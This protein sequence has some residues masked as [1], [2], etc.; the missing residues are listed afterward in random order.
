MLCL[1]QEGWCELFKRIAITF[2]AEH[3]EYPLKA[4]KPT[5]VLN[6]NRKCVILMTSET[7]SLKT[8][9]QTN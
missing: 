5:A 8:V 7:K 4:A 3:F 6:V 1:K 2:I 9:T